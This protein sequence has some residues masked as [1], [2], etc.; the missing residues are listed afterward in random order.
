MSKSQTHGLMSTGSQS[1]IYIAIKN[2]WNDINF[3]T[4]GDLYHNHKHMDIY[5]YELSKSVIYITNTWHDSNYESVS[6]SYH[7]HTSVSQSVI[8]ITITNTW[9][10]I[11]S[12]P[13]CDLYQYH[14]HEWPDISTKSQTVIPKMILSLFLWE[15]TMKYSEIPTSVLEITLNCSQ[16]I[17]LT[18]SIYTRYEILLDNYST[19]I[20]TISTVSNHTHRQSSI[21]STISSVNNH[22]I[23]TDNANISTISTGSYRM[24]LT[25][26]LVFLLSLQEVAM[27]YSQIMPKCLLSLQDVTIHVIFIDNAIISNISTGRHCVILTDTL[28]TYLQ[29]DTMLYSQTHF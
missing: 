8:Y 21:S 1:V 16:L 3:V 18:L 6:D 10:D 11:N 4:V 22:D 28:L 27:R 14:R 13:I 12:V 5:I 20:S 17:L 29:E 15:V 9:T 24:I 23:L 2:I 7:N 19:C 26:K 25:D